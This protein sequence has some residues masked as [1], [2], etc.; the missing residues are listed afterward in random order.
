MCKYYATASHLFLNLYQTV[1]TLPIK[2]LN[3][4]ADELK[5]MLQKQCYVT[6]FV[7]EQICSTLARSCRILLLVSSILALKH[8]LKDF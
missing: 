6:I 5:K 4:I 7:P 8:K 2:S 1:K 3:Q